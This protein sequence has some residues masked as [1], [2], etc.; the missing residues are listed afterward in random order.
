[1]LALQTGDRPECSVVHDDPDRGN[2]HLDSGC[3]DTRIRAERAIS[4]ERN[5]GPARACGLDAQHGRRAEPHRR[6][7]AWGQERVR[8]VDRILLRRRSCSSR[9]RSRGLRSGRRAG[10][11]QESPGSNGNS[12]EAALALLGAEEGVPPRASDPSRGTGPAWARRRRRRSPRGAPAS[13]V[14]AMAVG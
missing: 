4:D 9:R 13:A 7:T 11:P 10:R 1:M 3:D 5:R 12:E 2:C 14:A 6:E 8:G